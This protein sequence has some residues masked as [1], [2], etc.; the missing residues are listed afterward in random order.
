MGLRRGWS[1]VF[2]DR[3]HAGRRLAEEI[4]GEYV[5]AE[6]TIVLGIPRGGVVVAGE[7]ASRLGLPL[8]VVMASKIG[9]PGN[10]E[11]AVGAVDPDGEVVRNEQAGYS[12]S[13]IAHLVTPALDKIRKRLDLYRGGRPAP[14]MAG[15][16]AILVDDGVATGLTVEAAIAYLRRH[17]VERLVLATPVVAAD[18]AARLRPLVD[19]LV[20]VEEPALF[21]AVGQFYR[22]FEQ[23]SDD[24][25]LGILRNRTAGADSAE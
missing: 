6:G 20:A 3:R 23:T 17:G 10:P 22:H 18:T 19:V 11:F 13:E 12:P 4:G 24:E 1:L 25:V 14:E 2:R 15:A 16:T 5:G 9:A 8:D 21:L 7:V